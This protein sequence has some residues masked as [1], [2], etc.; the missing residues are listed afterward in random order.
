MEATY[1]HGTLDE[2][3]DKIIKKDGSKLLTWDLER[4]YSQNKTKKK[5]ETKK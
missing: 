4:G 2:V 1:L 3:R 5:T